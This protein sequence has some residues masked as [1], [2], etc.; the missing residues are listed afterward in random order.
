MNFTKGIS[1]VVK[2]QINVQDSSYS[3]MFSPVTTDGNLRWLV[4]GAFS[5]PPLYSLALF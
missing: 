1:K 3:T 4:G 2:P 5:D